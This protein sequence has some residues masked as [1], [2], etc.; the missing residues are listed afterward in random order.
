MGL[1]LPVSYLQKKRVVAGISYDPDAQAF[2]TA[3]GISGTTAD[4]INTLVIDLKFASLWTL[5]TAIYPLVGGTSS[6]TSYN[7]I[8]TSTFQVTWNGT[9]SFSTNGV[10]GDGSTGWGNTGLNPTSVGTFSS[11]AS[12]SAYIRT[13]GNSAAYDIGTNNY[14]A[15]AP[16][17]EWMIARF[18]NDRYTAF[19]NVAPGGPYVIASTT[20]YTGMFTGTNSSNTTIL[21]RNG[22]SLASAGKTFSV[23]TNS[24]ALCALGRPAGTASDFS[25]REYAWFSIGQGLDGTQA[26]DLNIIVANFQTTLGRNV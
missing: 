23:A 19:G 8:N 11:G 5:F 17:P 7:L 1:I 4:A 20:N 6:S 9:M 2:I 10:S 3:T 16:T 21:Y 12:L 24:I 14:P 26:S 25:S 18:T 13:N 22:S 15:D